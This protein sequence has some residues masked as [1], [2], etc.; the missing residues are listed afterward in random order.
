MRLIYAIMSGRVSGAINNRLRRNFKLY[1]LDITPEEWMVLNCLW[2]EDKKSQQQLCQE[3][4]REKPYMSRLI[5]RMVDRKLVVRLIS[6]K[7]K[8]INRVCLAQK[9]REIEEKVHF[10]AN[11]TLKEVLRGLSQEELDV[12]Q[13]S[14]R[15][16]F[17]NS[18]S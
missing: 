9:G 2:K 11:K 4:L 16:V 15:I 14:L 7:D 1:D 13:E 12:C 17:N 5:D 10:V 3:V 6:F 18:K 8:R